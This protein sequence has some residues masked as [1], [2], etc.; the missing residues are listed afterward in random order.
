MKLWSAFK[1]VFSNWNFEIAFPRNLLDM[2]II[3]VI[4]YIFNF[5]V[6]CIKGSQDIFRCNFQQCQLWKNSF[7]SV[8][9]RTTDLGQFT[10]CRFCAV[11]CDFLCFCM[12]RL[13]CAFPNHFRHPTLQLLHLLNTPPNQTQKF[14]YDCIDNYKIIY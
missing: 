1:N 12:L 2:C 3:P 10:A 11:F 7:L 9:W 5:R 8:F 14:Y 13:F 4:A 6:F